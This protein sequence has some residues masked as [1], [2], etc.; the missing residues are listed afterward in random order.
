MNGR[1]AGYI[2]IFFLAFVNPANAIEFKP[3][4]QVSPSIYSLDLELFNNTSN[5]VMFGGSLGAGVELYPWLAIE[6]RAGGSLS[7]TGDLAGIKYDSQVQLPLLSVFAKPMLDFDGWYLYG[8]LGATVAPDYTLVDASGRQTTTK[9]PTALSLG[10]GAGYYLSDSWSANIEAIQYHGQLGASNTLNAT[11]QGVGLTFNYYFDMSEDKPKEIRK[12]V[13]KPEIIKEEPSFGLHRTYFESS[14]AQLS[15]SAIEELDKIEIWL[16]EDSN[17]KLDIRGYTDATGPEGYN[18]WLSTQRAESVE[19]YL[20]GKGVDGA[21][22]FMMGLGEQNPV[23]GNATIEGRGQNRRVEILETNEKTALIK[24]ETILLRGVRF[25]TESAVLSERS[26]NS[27]NQ[28][29]KVLQA[30][31]A[32]KAEVLGHTDT[33][34]NAAYNRI[35]SKK[36]AYAVKAYLASQGVEDSRLLATGYGGSMPIANNVTREG[37]SLNRRVEVRLDY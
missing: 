2:F 36:R 8:L 17:L 18:L 14:S 5:N 31:P 20:L 26:K 1:A 27:L 19:S 3:Y 34:G 33:N 9:R 4:L 28:L 11:L 24:G 12:I 6:G 13:S 7:S 22:L 29:V 10:L 25:E 23:A 37:R 21:R 15:S 35:L 30:H 32:I 16:Q